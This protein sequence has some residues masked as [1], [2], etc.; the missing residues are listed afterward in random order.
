MYKDRRI[1]LNKNLYW[2]SSDDDTNKLLKLIIIDNA[3]VV[4]SYD[5]NPTQNFFINYICL[6]FPVGARK[7]K[8][9]QN[10]LLALLTIEAE[11]CLNRSLSKWLRI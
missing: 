7:C 3:S 1:C 4:H 2:Q 5:E 10:Q 6:F 9:L 11:A 8:P